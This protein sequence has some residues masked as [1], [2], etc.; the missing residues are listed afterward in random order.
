MTTLFKKIFTPV[1]KRILT[2][3]PQSPH[4]VFHTYNIEDSDN[5]IKSN[6]DMKKDTSKG[7][8][9]SYTRKLINHFSLRTHNQNYYTCPKKTRLEQIGFLS[10]GIFHDI[11]NPL[12]SLTL[13]IDQ[14]ESKGLIKNYGLAKE[15][16]ES[17]KVLMQFMQQM[18]LL[19]TEKPIIEKIHLSDLVQN[20]LLLIKNRVTTHNITI[21]HAHNTRAFLHGA[22]CR[23]QQVLLVVLNNAIDSCISNK[24]IHNYITISVSQQNR[25]TTITIKDTGCGIRAY[26]H[27]L[28][29]KNREDID[30]GYSKNNSSS[31]SFK[32]GI[33]L[34][35]ARTI[36]EK[37][38][39]G[40]LFLA[41]NTSGA[42]VTITLP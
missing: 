24:K 20:T 39:S 38:Y 21:L 29:E 40:T 37:E 6:S 31:E 35:H 15:M 41:N 17:K 33:G 2:D 4:T 9:F 8:L 11:L 10:R 16:L 12:A 7:Y 18:Q 28:S 14:L 19:I 23:M 22:A 13:H 34:S 26:T 30:S 27:P 5:D 25:A 1:T 36:I 3:S 42:Q 32:C